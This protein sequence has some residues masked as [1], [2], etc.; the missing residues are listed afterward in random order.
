M[1]TKT[2]FILSHFMGSRYYALPLSPIY[3]SLRVSVCVLVRRRPS[4]A[5][6]PPGEG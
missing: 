4:L 3:S 1:S 2:S 5:A 6:M